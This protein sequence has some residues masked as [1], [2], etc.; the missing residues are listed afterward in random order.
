MQPLVCEHFTSSVP[1]TL[2]TLFSATFASGIIP[3]EWATATVTPL[4]KRGDPLD[5]SDYRP[6]AVGVPLARLYASV[7]NR[8]ITPYLVAKNLRAQGQAGFCS[9]RSVNHYHFALQPVIDRHTQ[10]RKPL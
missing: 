4:F 6:V 3:D 2:A 7:L 8:R 5:T 9:R 10:Q 1:P